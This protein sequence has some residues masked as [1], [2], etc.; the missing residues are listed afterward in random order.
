MKKGN[1][2]I[3]KFGGSILSPD[4]TEA[5][6][7][8]F[9]DYRIPFDYDF[10]IEFLYLLKK[11]QD[12]RL[13]DK[14]VLIVGGGYLNKSYLIATIDYIQ[15]KMRKSK[16]IS[17]DLK[18]MIGS[19]SIALNAHV[20]LA[21]ATSLFGSKH[22]YQDTLK[23]S[24]Y[25]RIKSIDILDKIKVI[26]AAA[27]GPKHSSDTNAMTIADAFNANRVIS[28]KNVDGVYNSDPKENKNAKRFDEL[29]WK[30]YRKIL[31]GAKYEPRSHFPVDVIATGLADKSNT[32][33]IIMDGRDL[34]N[35]EAY[36]NGNNYKGT[37]ITNK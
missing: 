36:L 5:K 26:I 2:T 17:N 4:P 31:G 1:W 33:F 15:K 22:V 32:N 24:D 27:C 14:I 23:Y 13:I 37:I 9:S 7:D 29:T 28:L 25:E 10:S 35:F 30:Q 19:A 3:I 6:T 16:Q 8:R 34:G 11:S 12:Q 18:D 21:L 20:F